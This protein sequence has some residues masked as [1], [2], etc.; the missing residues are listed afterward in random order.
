MEM[1]FNNNLM[2]GFGTNV[3]LCVCD[4]FLLAVNFLACSRLFLVLVDRDSLSS[5]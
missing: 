4:R 3:S 2:F 1:K 5:L